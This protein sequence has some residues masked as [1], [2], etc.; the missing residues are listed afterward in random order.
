[1]FGT[2]SQLSV[3]SLQLSAVHG[4]ESLQ[5][6]AD[7]PWQPSTALHVSTPLQYWL[8]LHTAL[9]GA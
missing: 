7:P 9:L 8:S 5:F 4:T 2:L 6:G 1:L 3:T